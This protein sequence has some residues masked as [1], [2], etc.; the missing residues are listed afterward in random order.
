MECFGTGT[1]VIVSPIMNLHFK[2]VDY[3]IP[4]DTNLQCGPITR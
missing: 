2:G 4:V 1:A 3:N